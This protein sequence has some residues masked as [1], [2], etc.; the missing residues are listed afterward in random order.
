MPLRLP[1]PAADIQALRDALLQPFPRENNS[2]PSHDVPRERR[3]LY[4][5]KPLPVRGP[6]RAQILCA[7]APP[8]ARPAQMICKAL[9]NQSRRYNSFAASGERS[10]CPLKSKRDRTE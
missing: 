2:V 8:R 10:E 3:A 5:A 4:T 9:E 1:E 7:A 6:T